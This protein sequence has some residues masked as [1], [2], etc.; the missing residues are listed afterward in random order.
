MHVKFWLGPRV[1][2]RRINL[3]LGWKNSPGGTMGRSG[4]EPMCCKPAL[5]MP[6]E[7][8][9]GC[10]RS[11]G[12]QGGDL[13]E[14]PH[15]VSSGS[16]FISCFDLDTSSGDWTLFSVSRTWALFWGSDVSS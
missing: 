13:W 6:R 8:E 3:G 2:L 15:F 16:P 1:A 14:G 12:F 7:I 4:A 5:C 9:V 10:E 11:H